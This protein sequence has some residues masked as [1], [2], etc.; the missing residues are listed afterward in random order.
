MIGELALGVTVFAVL[1]SWPTRTPEPTAPNPNAL[2]LTISLLTDT[3]SASCGVQPLPGD[4]REEAAGVAGRRAGRVELTDEFFAE[5]EVA[6]L[7][8]CA[9]NTP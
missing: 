3:I 2:A 8:W 5:L 7:H 4:V 6:A 1:M 9:G